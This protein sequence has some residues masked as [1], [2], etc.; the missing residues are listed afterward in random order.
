MSEKH[1][2]F[3]TSLVSRNVDKLWDPVTCDGV[4]EKTLLR[5]KILSSL[6]LIG[7]FLTRA[8][9]HLHPLQYCPL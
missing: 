1:N 4:Y 5:L 7:H 3:Y 9:L 8:N 6:I 2:K